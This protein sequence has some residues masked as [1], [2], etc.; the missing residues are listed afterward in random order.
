[1]KISE[2]LK[3]KFSMENNPNWKGG[4]YKSQGRYFVRAKDHINAYQ[5]GYVLRARYIVEQEIGRY[6]TP[7]EQVHHINFTKT[8]DR[9]ENLYLFPSAAEHARYHNLLEAQ[10]TKMITESNLS[11]C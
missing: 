1:M 7:E 11:S 2:S 9:V 10:K 4:E 5:N 6:L 8:D 3:G